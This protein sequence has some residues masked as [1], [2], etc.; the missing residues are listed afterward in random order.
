MLVMAV[1]TVYFLTP[2]WWLFV[3]ST[4]AGAQVIGS[5]GLWFD[6][7]ELGENIGT[8]LT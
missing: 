5:G 4:K 1:C 2:L 8:V 7:F 6:E 3:G